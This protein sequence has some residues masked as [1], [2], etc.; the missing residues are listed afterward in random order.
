MNREHINRL[1]SRIPT[2]LIIIGTIGLISG[3]WI[4]SAG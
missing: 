4:R 1:L 2:H 3:A